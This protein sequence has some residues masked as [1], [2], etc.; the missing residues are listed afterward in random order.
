VWEKCTRGIPV[1]NPNEVEAILGSR[2]RRKKQFYLVKWLGYGH[3]DNTWEPLS[4][5]RDAKE[6][7]GEF[8]R[9]KT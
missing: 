9:G 5:L 8:R 7:I 4:N 2:K 3:E 1:T 6:A